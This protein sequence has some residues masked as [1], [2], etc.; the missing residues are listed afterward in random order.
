MYLDSEKGPGIG[1]SDDNT[2]DLVFYAKSDPNQECILTAGGVDPCT[3]NV[4][5][6]LSSDSGL[7]FAEPIQLNEQSIEGRDFARFYG[8]SQPGSHLAVASGDEF[9]YPMWIGTP[10]NGKTRIYIA[11]IER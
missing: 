1:M 9:A 2:I 6:T 11:K 4:Y 8:L 10:E 7:S 3:Y 5:Y